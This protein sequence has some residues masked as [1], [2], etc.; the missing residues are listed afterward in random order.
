MV[1]RRSPLEYIGG[2]ETHVAE[3]S[4]RLASRGVGVK[5]LSTSSITKI[6]QRRVISGVCFEI[7]PAIAP[8]EIE[9]LSLPLYRRL[10]REASEVLHVQGYQHLHFL[11]SVL[12]KKKEQR[13][14]VTLH[15]G[16]HG[17]RIVEIRNSCY[18]LFV[19]KLLQRADRIIGVS[20]FDLALFGLSPDRAAEPRKTAVLP[21]GV[22]LTSLVL[23]H[24]LPESVPSDARFVLSVGR[25]VRDKGHHTVI[26]S[27]ARLKACTAAN[28]DLKLVIA[29][30]GPY[31]WKLRELIRLF[32]LQKDV[33]ILNNLRREELI[34]LYQKCELFVLLSR[35]ECYG[36]AVSEAIAL[37]KPALVSETSALIDFIRKGWCIGVPFPFRIDLVV[38][39]MD[40]MLRNP[41]RFVPRNVR[42]CTWD[43]VADRLK[44]IYRETLYGN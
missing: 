33:L 32:K 14:F 18:R 12:S 2:V 22:D 20:S 27:F 38:S 15:S 9:Y 8:G 42:L 19:R 28:S 43:E 40:E 24:D 21:N 29:G 1:C 39:K 16:L 17:S 23:K 30:S 5:V 6:P 36:L 35:Y 4:R 3:I 34:A 25:L 44:G 13:L 26:E 37:G 10:R 31:E 41:E 11:P 7:Y